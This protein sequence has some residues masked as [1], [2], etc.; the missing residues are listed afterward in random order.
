MLCSGDS[1]GTFTPPFS[2]RRKPV[3]SVFTALHAGNFLDPA[4][5]VF[6]LDIDK[7]VNRFGDQFPLRRRDNFLN[8]LFEPRQPSVGAVCVNCG[9]SARVSGIPRF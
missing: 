6:P 3:F 2:Y 4:S 7:Q 9:D 8:E 1:Q 5:V